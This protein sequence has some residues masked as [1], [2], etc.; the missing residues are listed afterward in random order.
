MNKRFFIFSLVLSCAA[1]LMA[2][3]AAKP[4][5]DKG[6]KTI[7]NGKN[8]KGWTGDPKVWSVQDGVI[9]GRNT[10]EEPIKANT[11]LI[12]TNG[13]VGDFEL[14]LSY[15][16]LNGNSGIQ[17]RSKVLDPATWLVGGYQAD[18]EAGTKWSGIL[19]DEKGRGILGERGQK[20]VVKPGGEGKK[21]ASVQVVG[22]VGNPD[23]IQ[24]KI[25]SEDWNDYVVIAK[26]NHLIHK[27]NGV[28]TV[29]VTDEDAANAAKSGILAFQV[30]TGPP[31][32]VMFKDVR[33]KAL[34]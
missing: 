5:A 13:T 1:S 24:A 7:F 27:I 11:F 34:K 31:M 4:K 17:Y 12:W 3:A 19:Y 15:K 20:T 9:V 32:T 26:D 25:K 6:F 28:T 21:K 18:F 2:D 10:A 22:S 29:E 33:V 14:R 16:I 8:L 23:E 30:H